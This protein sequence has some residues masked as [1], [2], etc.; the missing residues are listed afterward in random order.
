MNPIYI[1]KENPLYK[2][3]EE[4]KKLEKGELT[5]EEGYEVYSKRIFEQLNYY[6]IPMKARIFDHIYN[7]NDAH[8]IPRI[9]HY[10]DFESVWEY[11]IPVGLNY[12]NRIRYHRI[13]VKVV[14]KMNQDQ[15]ENARNEIVGKPWQS[16]GIIDG[17]TIF[18]ASRQGFAKGGIKSNNS[19][20]YVIVDKDPFKVAMR[21]LAFITNAIWKR[22]LAFLRSI[23]MN[24]QFFIPKVQDFININELCKYISLIYNKIYSIREKVRFYSQNIRKTFDSFENCFKK[25]IDNLKQLKDTIEYRL[26]LKA[27]IENLKNKQ[28]QEISDYEIPGPKEILKALVPIIAKTK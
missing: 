1:S 27:F 18:L 3:Y 28:S 10:T 4:I 6:L 11:Y 19:V 22:F 5:F 24:W 25:F 20:I 14:D 12:E 23:K 8:G 7:N 17:E 9:Y 21:I 15:V 13:F 26:S 16:P 2:L